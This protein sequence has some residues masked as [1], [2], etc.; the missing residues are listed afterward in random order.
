[1]DYQG[2]TSV[3]SFYFLPKTKL[4]L[5]NSLTLILAA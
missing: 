3:Y 4:H 1:M 2:L 5:F